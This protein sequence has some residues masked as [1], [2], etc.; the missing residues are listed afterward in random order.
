M[1]T[2][3]ATLM[4]GLYQKKAG[5]VRFPKL[6]ASNELTSLSKGSTTGSD[7]LVSIWI[8]YTHVG[9]SSASVCKPQPQE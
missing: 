9:C 1:Y 2:C 6:V 7:T 5:C 8:Q 3:M 4:K